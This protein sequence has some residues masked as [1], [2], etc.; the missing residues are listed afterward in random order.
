M[1]NKCGPAARL[2]V[3]LFSV[4]K[5]DGFVLAISF[6]T[7]HIFKFRFHWCRTCP[8]HCMETRID[9]VFGHI[10][11]GPNGYFL[12]SLAIVARHNMIRNLSKIGFQAKNR[13]NVDYH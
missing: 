11:L 5:V 7:M 10:R 4:F 3:K 9:L 2:N 6:Y 8:I 13:T 12:T 1:V